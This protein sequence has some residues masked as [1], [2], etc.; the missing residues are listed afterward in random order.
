MLIITSAQRIKEKR[1]KRKKVKDM[2]HM[3]DDDIMISN[4]KRIPYL[5]KC[6]HVWIINPNGITDKTNPE[7]T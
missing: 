4:H 5:P 1:K 7:L 6:A 3:T 2:S